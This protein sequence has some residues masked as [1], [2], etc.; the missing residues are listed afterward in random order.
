M[1]LIATNKPVGSL[2]DPTHSF[3]DDGK[4]VDYTVAQYRRD[5]MSED[6]LKKNFLWLYKD[7]GRDS[8]QYKARLR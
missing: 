5:L 4:K 2:E 3:D 8:A 6:Q 7:Y 1:W